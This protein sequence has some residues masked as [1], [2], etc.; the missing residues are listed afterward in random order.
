MGFHLG[1]LHGYFFLQDFWP[2][3]NFLLE[4][5]IRLVLESVL[6]HHVHFNVCYHVHFH[7]CHH[8]HFLFSIL[9]NFKK[10]HKHTG[11]IFDCFFAYLF[12]SVFFRTPALSFVFTIYIYIY[13]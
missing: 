6:K 5:Q 7:V 10:S 3:L 13:I 9:R 11:T 8:V 12:S 4:D 1:T 2:N